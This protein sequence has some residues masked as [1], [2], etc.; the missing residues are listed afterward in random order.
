MRKTFEILRLYNDDFIF[1]IFDY[2]RKYID[3]D[4]YYINFKYNNLLRT[5]FIS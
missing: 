5:Q 4:F 2:F 1:K 3:E